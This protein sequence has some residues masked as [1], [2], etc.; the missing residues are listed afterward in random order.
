[1]SLSQALLDFGSAICAGDAGVCF[2]R[3]RGWRLCA[4]IRSELRRQDYYERND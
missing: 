4:N 1:M 2:E 3:G